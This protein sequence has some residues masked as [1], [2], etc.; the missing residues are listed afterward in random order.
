M[1]AT[2]TSVPEHFV[3]ELKLSL[4]VSTRAE[5]D[6]AELDEPSGLGYVP[7]PTVTVLADDRPPH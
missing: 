4:V 7:R 2:W 3:G 1:S 6:E 5:L